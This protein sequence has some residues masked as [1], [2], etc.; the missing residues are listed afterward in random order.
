M[1]EM[2]DI[3]A[4]CS[5]NLAPTRSECFR[6]LSVQFI[7]QVDWLSALGQSEV[8]HDDAAAAVDVV[9][10][11]WY[12]PPPTSHRPYP[13]ISLITVFPSFPA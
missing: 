11:L 3:P 2:E 10:V 6:N 7:T 5:A 4:L 13:A 9:V 8:P 1:E 12:A